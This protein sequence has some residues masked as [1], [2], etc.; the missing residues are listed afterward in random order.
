[1]EH[2]RLGGFVGRA[3]LATERPGEN[4]W[5]MFTSGRSINERL[6][7]LSQYTFEAPSRAS[8]RL[9]DIRAHATALQRQQQK[10]LVKQHF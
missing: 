1:M 7:A 10:Q 3:L 5:S 2:Q 4:E 8:Q 9:L 6:R